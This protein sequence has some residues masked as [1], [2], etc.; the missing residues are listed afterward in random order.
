MCRVLTAH[1]GRTIGEQA[2]FTLKKCAA[3]STAH[4]GANFAGEGAPGAPRH[5]PPI[6]GGARP[7]P[8]PKSSLQ[9]RKETPMSNR[10]HRRPTNPIRAELDRLV[11]LRIPG[12]CDDCLAYQEIEPVGGIHVL[13]IRH[14]D[15]CPTLARIEGRR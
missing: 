7:A 13:H 5:H 3:R 14:D 6:G 11:G 1:H 12:G 10:P 15:T 8:T 2:G 9:N 4:C